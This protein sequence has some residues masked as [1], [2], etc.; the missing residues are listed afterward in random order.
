MILKIKCDRIYTPF[1]YSLE[2]VYLN[3]LG[4]GRDKEDTMCPLNGTFL[5]PYK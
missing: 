3:T 2:T 1:A 4:P 5:D